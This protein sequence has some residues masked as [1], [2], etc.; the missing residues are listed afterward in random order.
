MQNP[1]P[2]PARL[3]T[4]GLCIALVAFALAGWA[5]PSGES[6]A[7]PLAF[8]EGDTPAA[9]TL[10]ARLPAAWPDSP[11]VYRFELVADIMPPAWRTVQRAVAEAHALDADALLVQLDTY[12][13]MVNIADSISQR[14]LHARMPVIVY[15]ANNAASAGALISISCDAIYMAP[16]SQIGAATVVN[17]TDGQAMPDKYQAYMRAKM[18]SIAEAQGRDPDIAEAMVDQDLEVPGVV[19]AGKTLVFT[20]SEAMANGYCEGVAEDWREALALAGLEDYRV[21][22]FEPTGV[23]RVIQF[24]VNPMVAGILMLVIFFGIYAELQSPGVGFPLL[25]AAIAATL[26]FAPH[27]LDGLAASWEIAVF[28]LGVVL[29]AVELFVLPGFGVA[30][31]SGAALM[32]IALVLSLLAN[33]NFDFRFV[34][35]ED[36]ARAVLTV[37]LALL[38]AVGLIITF[39]GSLGSSPLLRR[40]VLNE[41]QERERGFRVDAFGED[42]PAMAGRRAVALTDLRPAGRVRLE[43]DPDGTPHDALTEGGYTPAGTALTV[44]AVRGNQ[45]LVREAEPDHA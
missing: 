20:P 17:G 4:V 21:A 31:V 42:G 8:A 19:E 37:M 32:V 41:A 36:V 27:Y 18:R 16:S 25:A 1:S 12:G 34:P 5:A 22:V 43:G 6:P 2:T 14:L 35:S 26:Y 3:H 39:L 28:A 15:I 7:P 45:L 11:L 10:P 33:R 29:L 13:G 38:G 23:D 24:L 9:D 30:G 44:V 40:L